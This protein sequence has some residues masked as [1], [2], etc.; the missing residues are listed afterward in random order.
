MLIA[1]LAIGLMACG[2]RGPKPKQPDH[3]TTPATVGVLISYESG[4][5]G[6]ALFH[7]DSGE[8][9]ELPTDDCDG[10]RLRQMLG[11]TRS[12]GG[13]PGTRLDGGPLMMFGSD[14]QGPW[15]AVAH[16]EFGSGTCYVVHTG[17]YLEGRAFHFP[18]GLLLPLAAGFKVEPEYV[19]ADM[20]EDIFPL[21]TTDDICLDRTG[22]V[23]LLRIAMQH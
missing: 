4:D 16:D 21:R 20:G 22:A 11:E 6:P 14:E 15:Y 12:L 19:Y 5:C 8:T 1:A 18:S 23:T 3:V 7:L 2:E 9:I 17:A 10:A 13:D